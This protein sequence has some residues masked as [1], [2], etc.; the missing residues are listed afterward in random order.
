MLLLA[1]SFSWSLNGTAI[2]HVACLQE[3]GVVVSYGPEDDM[4]AG[5][6]WEF[7]VV[8]V[9]RSQWGRLR[10]TGDGRLDF[11]H[12]QSSNDMAGLQPGQGRQTVRTQ[13]SRHACSVNRSL[14]FLSASPCCE[15][16]FFV[17]FCCGHL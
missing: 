16:M 3:D 12:A 13:M 4:K 6:A 7:G 10:L 9:D 5:E 1:L 8:L 14:F 17:C 11:L 2:S 15:V